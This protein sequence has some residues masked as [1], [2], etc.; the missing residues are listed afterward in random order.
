MMPAVIMFHTTVVR[1]VEQ[2]VLAVCDF[3][4]TNPE[5]LFDGLDRH[6][7]FVVVAGAAHDIFP[8]GDFYH[9]KFDTIAQVDI[10]LIFAEIYL[11]PVFK[12]LAAGDSVGP[13]FDFG[14]IANRT[15]F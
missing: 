10:F 13:A 5:R 7:F 9:L 3:E 6:R 11:S 12:T 8:C 2:T 4:T 15:G 14:S 1:I